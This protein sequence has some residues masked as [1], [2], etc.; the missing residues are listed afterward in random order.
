MAVKSINIIQKCSVRQPMVIVYHVKRTV[1]TIELFILISLSL[2]T[3]N[4]NVVTFY[5]GFI[6]LL[7]GA[8]GFISSPNFKLI[9]ALVSDI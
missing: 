7:Y 9:D 2:V 1:K 6:L 4:T 3:K 5:F 8:K